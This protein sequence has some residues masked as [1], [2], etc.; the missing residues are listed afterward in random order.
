MIREKTLNSD[1]ASKVKKKK[2]SPKKGE[3]SVEKA[4]RDL[5]VKSLHLEEL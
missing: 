5:N 4:D 3:K 2:N 1:P